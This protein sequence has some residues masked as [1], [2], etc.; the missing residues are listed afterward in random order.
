[1]KVVPTFHHAFFFRG[2]DGHDIIGT[3]NRNEV[4]AALLE[5]EILPS[6]F[7]SW[8]SIGRMIMSSTD[9]IKTILHESTIAKKDVEDQ[10]QATVLKRRHEAWAMF[11]E[12]WMKNNVIFLSFW[13]FLL[14]KKNSNA[15]KHFMTQR[16]GRTERQAYKISTVVQKSKIWFKSH[17]TSVKI[18]NSRENHW[19][20][21]ISFVDPWQRI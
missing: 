8:D 14:A 17:M 2:M 6:S 7:R 3:L 21:F 4:R 9:I 15:M 11:E 19:T 20:G 13:L 5:Q 10:H 1:M 18:K 16:H 12:M